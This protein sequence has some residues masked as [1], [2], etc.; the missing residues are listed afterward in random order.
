MRFSGSPTSRRK[1]GFELENG[2][3]CVFSSNCRETSA[4]AARKGVS[5]RDPAP[6]G[7]I[8]NNF[9]RRELLREDFRGTSA[10]LEAPESGV[11]FPCE[12][13]CRM[14]SIFARRG[15]CG[16][17]FPY[18]AEKKM[19]KWLVRQGEVAP[20]GGKGKSS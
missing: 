17:S 13:A 14:G 19:K 3:T 7:M 5:G 12:G 11:S 1:S 20:D 6:S 15:L 2:V 9:E 18:G 8:V 4:K 10:A 16:K